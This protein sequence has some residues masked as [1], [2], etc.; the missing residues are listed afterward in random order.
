MVVVA[1]RAE[2][3]LRHRVV[4]K[5]IVGIAKNDVADH[6][7][8]ILRRRRQRTERQDSV[9]EQHPKIPVGIK[10][11]GSAKRVNLSGRILF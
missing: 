7:K 1:G 10:N 11:G 9:R 2:Q 5:V 6:R 8:S 3:A 4:R